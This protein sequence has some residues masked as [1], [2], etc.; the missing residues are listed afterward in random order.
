IGP[1]DLQ[2]NSALVFR[3]DTLEKSSIS[4]SI[5]AES[6]KDLL[7][8]IHADMLE[9][10]RAQY[11]AKRKLIIRWEDFVPALNDKCVCVIPWCNRE[12]CED[13][14]KERS[15]NETMLGMPED[16]KAPSMGAKSLC[17]PY[18][19]TPYSPIQEGVTKCVQCNQDAKVYA[20]FGRSY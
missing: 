20:M 1:K 5:I 6:V 19:Q 13:R 17:I 7:E 8:T 18:D 11:D 15:A 2:N 3:R 4:L 9:K 12:E 10:A 14:I 16:S